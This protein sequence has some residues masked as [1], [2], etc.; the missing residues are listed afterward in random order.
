VTGLAI[1]AFAAGVLVGS[2]DRNNARR[3]LQERIQ[4]YRGLVAA[5]KKLEESLR[6]E[7]DVRPPSVP[8]G[9]VGAMG[10]VEAVRSSLEAFLPSFLIDAA[11]HQFEPS[12]FAIR[13][14]IGGQVACVHVQWHPSKS[15]LPYDRKIDVTPTGHPLPMPAPKTN[16]KAN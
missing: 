8:T 12:G 9:P 1:L 13:L 4:A 16:P 10:G 6:A 5:L 11:D 15:T 7:L 2:L 14:S 3:R